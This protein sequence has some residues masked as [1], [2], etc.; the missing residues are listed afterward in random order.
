MAEPLF[1]CANDLIRMLGTPDAPAII[2]V[3]LPEDH[4]CDPRVIPGARRMSHTACAAHR[5]I[6]KQRIIDG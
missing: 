3:C 6:V 4:A 1:I 5:N 2:D